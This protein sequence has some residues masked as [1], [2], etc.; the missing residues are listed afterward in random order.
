MIACLP[1]ESKE[2]LHKGGIITSTSTSRPPMF[3]YATFCK[4]LSIHQINYR[5][6][7]LLRNQPSISSQSLNGD[8]HMTT[9]EEVLKLLMSQSSLRKLTFSL[10]LSLSIPKITSFPGAKVCL[11]NLSELCCDSDIYSEFFYQLSQICH[12][13]QSLNIMFYKV[14]SNG[15]SDL[16]SAQQNLKY[17]K[18][19][20]YWENEVLTANI[21]TSLSNLPNTLIKLDLYGNKR[22]I[23]LSFI[24]KFI[25]LQEIIISYYNYYESD[26][27]ALQ[28]VTFSKLQI[29]KFQCENP[30][31]ESLIKFLE[32]NGR[33][34]KEFYS[35]CCENSLKLAIA[36]FCPNLRKLFTGCR[37]NE[38]EAL[39][40]IFNNCQ[41]L[42]S[43]KIW[44]GA[45]YYLS[46]K[47]LLEV[48]AEYSPRNIHELKLCYE[49]DMESE[50]LPEELESFFISWTNRVPQKS[51]SFIIICND[52][53]TLVD[54][55]ES[56]QIIEEYIELGIIKE[57]N[58]IE[59]DD[60]FYK[61]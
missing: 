10:N 57:F 45:D 60:D 50:L 8:L 2:N 31:H 48:V 9:Q 26:F 20:R 53:V 40:K 7:Q 24:T 22:D 43:I 4:V 51:L 46:E 14:I 32:N 35:K 39:K 52:A 29:L 54:N 15:L 33:N 25:N 59:Y 30:E 1:N 18:I 11:K 34:L 55:D 28:Y 16:I 19:A 42:E 13:L 61:Y 27:K 23:P 38:L 5:I 58:T 47:V 17:L 12:N 37:I 36:E 56:M 49:F 44:C 6:R 3:N 41:Y 21:I